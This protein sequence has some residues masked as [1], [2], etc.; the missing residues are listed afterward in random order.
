MRL[1]HS[2]A[3]SLVILV[4]ALAG[5]GGGDGSRTAPAPS[6]AQQSAQGT[7][8]AAS[9]AARQELALPTSEFRRAIRAKLPA[10]T[11]IYHLASFDISDGTRSMSVV[12]SIQQIKTSQGYDIVDQFGERYHVGPN[13]RI[14]PNLAGVEYYVRPGAVVPKSAANMKPSEIVGGGAM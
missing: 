3:A 2:A 1:K 4:F 11:R 13:V 12:G 6:V 14:V 5:C 7:A 10:G 9:A 8:V